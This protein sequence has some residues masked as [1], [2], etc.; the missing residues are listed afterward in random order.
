M[1][2]WNK[3][4]LKETILFAEE[5][6]MFHPLTFII[7]LLALCWALTEIKKLFHFSEPK[8][9]EKLRDAIVQTVGENETN[10]QKLEGVL[11]DYEILNAELQRRENI[12]LVIGTILIAASLLI[13]GQTAVS[14]EIGSPMGVSA[15]SSIGLFALW[16]Y[17]LHGTGKKLDD[18]AL[19]RAR[20]L[21][22]AV[23]KCLGY[24][25]G[26]HSYTL[27]E[28]R[29]RIGNPKLWLRRRRTFWF[30]VLGLLSFSW[31]LL[32]LIK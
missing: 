21:E 18:I 28:T 22:E 3:Y 26:I 10:Y 23:S 17:F 12:S 5:T 29:N 11:K 15:I 20:A 7:S 16:L 13:F 32:S 8:T 25:F 27:K 4:I 24:E 19:K 1:V 14:E 9:D 6:N 31:L 30:T 2:E